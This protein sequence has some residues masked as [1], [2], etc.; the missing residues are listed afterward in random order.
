LWENGLLPSL[1]CFVGNLFGVTKR[2]ILLAEKRG[3]FPVR[4]DPQG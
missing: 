4:K 1:S 2:G 3:P